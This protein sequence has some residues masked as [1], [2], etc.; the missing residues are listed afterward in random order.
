MQTSNEQALS[1]GEIYF[2]ILRCDERT[3]AE[4]IDWWWAQIQSTNER[5]ELQKLFAKT[6]LNAAFRKL[7]LMPALAPGMRAGMVGRLLRLKSD[8]EA[9][10]FLTHIHDSWLYVLDHNLDHLQKIN[11]QT[12]K[13][14]EGRNP[15][16]SL[17][18]RELLKSLAQT[19]AIFGSFSLPE[20][21]RILQNLQGFPRRIPSLYLF[22]KDFKY[23]EG[24]VSCQKRLI[25]PLRHRT[26]LQSLNHSFVGQRGENHAIGPAAQFDLAYRKLYLFIMRNLEDLRPG[27][28]L[29]EKGERRQT[30][31]Q[32]AR[33]W[34]DLALEAH[35][36]G[37]RSDQITTLT[38]QNPDQIEA[39]HAL[40][41]ARNPM[42]FVYD[43]SD[44]EASVNAMLELFAKAKRIDS[45]HEPVC[46]VRDGSGEGIERRFG[47]PWRRAHAES[48][49]H[50]YLENMHCPNPSRQGELTP[51]FIRRDVYLS[52]FG[53]LEQA[54]GDS[55]A[56]TSPPQT[57]LASLSL[58]SRS[59]TPTGPSSALVLHRPSASG[60]QND[61]MELDL[62]G[63]PV[64]S[65]HYSAPSQGANAIANPGHDDDPRGPQDPR[66]P[67]ALVVQQDYREA[68]LIQFVLL[69]G[70]ERSVVEEIVVIEGADPVVEQVAGRYASRGFGLF[71]TSFRSLAPSQCLRAAL[72]DSNQTVLLIP[73]KELH[74]TLIVQ[75]PNR[76]RHAD[77][78]LR[79]RPRKFLMTS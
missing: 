24:L 57:P 42:N 31:E 64:S 20:R 78:E 53:H 32:D 60:T 23:L 25:S 66:S 18:D 63:S 69:T 26:V 41:R 14:V 67:R 73:P 15:A 17:S 43:E 62:A 2:H 56:I 68:T 77:D 7:A 34:Y 13:Q 59:Q 39:R 58:P 46:L 72:M 75:R 21:N 11:H 76:K 16:N 51:F 28:V 44:L 29:L 22:F 6:N 47:W 71:D 50:L 9:I 12:L 19:G 38:S 70:V 3:D 48:A 65:S 55:D 27:S 36:L 30:R 33:A 8:E 45:G 74:E 54:V 4:M 61:A 1:A 52:F 40:L 49:R 10:R 37:F 79:G 5:E 35:R